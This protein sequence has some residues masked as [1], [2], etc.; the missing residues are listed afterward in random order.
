MRATVRY[1]IADYK[2][3]IEIDCDENE[4]DNFIIARAKKIVTQ[5]AG[6]SLPFGSETWKVVDRF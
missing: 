5:R 6:G 1:Q 3:V 2:G 4:E